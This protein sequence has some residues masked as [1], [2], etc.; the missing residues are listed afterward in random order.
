MRSRATL[1]GSFADVFSKIKEAVSK[2]SVVETEEKAKAPLKR[3][4]STLVNAGGDPVR[5]LKRRA[6]IVDELPRRSRPTKTQRRAGSI[7]GPK[8][9]PPPPTEAAPSNAG[10]SGGAGT[11]LPDTVSTPDARVRKSVISEAERDLRLRSEWADIDTLV[12]RCGTA[13]SRRRPVPVADIVLIEIPQ[14]LV[15]IGLDFG[16]AF[17]KAV[18]RYR[19]RDHVVSWGDLVDLDHPCLL[20]SCFSE[21]LGGDLALGE[22]RSKGWSTFD[23]LKMPLLE[24]DETALLDQMARQNAVLFLALVISHIQAW[25]RERVAGAKQ[26]NLQWRLHMGL[27]SRTVEGPRFELFKRVAESAYAL[28]SRAEVI[29]RSSADQIDGVETGRVTLIPEFRA[30]I[31]AYLGSPQRQP[32]LHVLI[33]LGGGT[34]DV[35]YFLCHK[36]SS[37]ANVIQIL[38]SDVK[39][40]GTHYLLAAAVGR[41]GQ[42][43]EWSDN[44]VASSI[45]EISKR[46]GESKPRIQQ[47]IEGYRGMLCRA[48][49]ECYAI[50]RR[51][52]SRG[53]VF[54]GDRSLPVMVCGG[55]AK[56]ETIRTAIST[57]RQQFAN[58]G[59][60]HLQ[61]ID[62]PGPDQNALMSS[63]EVE[64]DRVAVAHGLCERR[65]NL[66]DVLTPEGMEPES[67]EV[68]EAIDRDADR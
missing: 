68:R 12:V 49:Y 67:R 18:V 9:E 32:D 39:P 30:Q 23:G 34:V 63:V 50:A 55:G 10:T 29:D 19:N 28:A 65:I 62:L 14:E 7:G 26:G 1:G 41:A 43:L 13:S 36:T 58:N 44:D 4:G 2:D 57:L 42:H 17:T 37:G 47:R 33:D 60:A 52:Y 31:Q 61:P 3:D 59:M 22:V 38:S 53:P 16:T 35:A 48:V 27:P 56:L 8:P 64:Y 45:N 20:P 21:N 66:G 51:Y 25:T 11:T 5:L 24:C 54:L 46:S 6:V 40:L 15:T